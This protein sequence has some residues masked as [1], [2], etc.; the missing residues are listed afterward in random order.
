[1]MPQ[2]TVREQVEVNA[3]LKLKDMTSEERR[4]RVR[5]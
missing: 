1:M 4:E 2:L 5:F 3:E